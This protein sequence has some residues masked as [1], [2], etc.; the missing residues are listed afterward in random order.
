M[1]P[2][3]LE[4]VAI[5]LCYDRPRLRALFVGYEVHDALGDAYVAGDDDHLRLVGFALARGGFVALDAL[6]SL[7]PSGVAIDDVVMIEPFPPADTR[8]LRC[9]DAGGLRFRL[10]DGRLAD[11]PKLAIPA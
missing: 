4:D 9:A 8:P 3:A 11:A 5:D 1:L 2:A 7:M 10:R 6:S